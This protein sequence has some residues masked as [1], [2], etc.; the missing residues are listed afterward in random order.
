MSSMEGSNQGDWHLKRVTDSDAQAPWM[1]GALWNSKSVPGKT[2]VLW[3]GNSGWQYDTSYRFQVT[4]F[5]LLDSLIV[6]CAYI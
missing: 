2:E 6:S 4:K 3:T 1:K 5:K